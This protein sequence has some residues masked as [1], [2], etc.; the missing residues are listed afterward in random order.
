MEGRRLRKCAICGTK[1]DDAKKACEIC[2]SEKFVD[3]NGNLKSAIEEAV[4]EIVAEMR[5]WNVEVQFEADDLTGIDEILKWIQKNTKSFEE[6]YEGHNLEIVALTGGGEKF[7]IVTMFWR[8]S[9][10]DGVLGVA[11]VQKLVELRDDE[12]EQPSVFRDFG[13]ECHYLEEDDDE[14]FQD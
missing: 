14:E 2:D 10:E 7:N 4:R 13:I 6:N 11:L 1:W 12:A 3:L 5:G 8:F 9:L